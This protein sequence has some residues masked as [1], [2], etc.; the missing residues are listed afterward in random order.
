MSGCVWCDESR[1]FFL[2]GTRNFSF[3]KG[4]RAVSVL[5]FGAKRNQFVFIIIVIRCGAVW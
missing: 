5:L 1:R 2:C 4:V 3:A